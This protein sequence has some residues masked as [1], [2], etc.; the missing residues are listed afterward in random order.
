MS[1]K[2]EI[3]PKIGVA[4][5]GNSPEQYYLSP[6]TVGG[7]PVRC[8]LKTGDVLKNEDGYAIRRNIPN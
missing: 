5:L 7:L 2:F 6:E 1:Q 8:D 3:H 4:R